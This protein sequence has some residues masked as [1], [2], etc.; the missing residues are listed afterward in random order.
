MRIVQTLRGVSVPKS[1]A[2]V[3][4]SSQLSTV[5]CCADISER[6]H[7]QYLGIDSVLGSD[8]RPG[9]YAHALLLNGMVPCVR[10]NVPTGLSS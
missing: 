6:S 1:G 3:I 10:D 4:S 8:R 7:F 9:A 5:E 2:Q